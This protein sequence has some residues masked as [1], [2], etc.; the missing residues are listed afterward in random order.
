[1]QRMIAVLCVA[2]GLTLSMSA[3]ASP[4]D[5]TLHAL[6]GES[7]RITTTADQKHEG[8]LYSF[9]AQQIVV[10]DHEG[11]VL[12]L[13]R[14]ALEKIQLPQKTHAAAPS[15]SDEAERTHASSPPQSVAAEDTPQ[16]ASESATVMEH[17]ARAKARADFLREQRDLERT[18]SAYRISGGVITGVGALTAFSAMMSLAIT[19]PHTETWGGGKSRD[20]LRTGAVI[21][22]VVGTAITA[23]GVGL[24]VMGN[25]KRR[26]A[27]ANYE[28]SLEYSLSPQF[29]AR[30]GGAEMRLRF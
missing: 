13:Q 29:N 21:T 2:L 27:K 16:R 19:G 10:V 25:N 28:R 4:S 5:S 24:I 15:K 17:D 12:E 3:W 8:V 6:E 18:G 23:S 7:V 22:A 1:M 9:D 20:T 14:N 26:R 11:N 30:G